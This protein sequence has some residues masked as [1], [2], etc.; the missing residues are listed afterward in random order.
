M[1]TLLEKLVWDKQAEADRLKLELPLRV[2][3]EKLPTEPRYDFGMALRTPGTHII[4]ELPVRQVQS[5]M[6]A[7]NYLTDLALKYQTGGASALSVIC[8]GR[9]PGA[10]YEQLEAVKC[11][12]GLPVLCKEIIV[13]PYQIHYARFMNADAVLLMAGIMTRQGLANCLKVTA[14]LNLTAIVEVHNPHEVSIAV[15]AGATNISCMAAEGTP[16]NHR[17]TAVKLANDLSKDVLKI[18]GAG[19][20]N[21]GDLEQ[22]KAAGFSAFIVGEALAQAADPAA[23]IR[24][25]H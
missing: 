13:D 7:D 23:L 21:S 22:L 19:I 6:S 8:D 10:R 2:I 17:E 12:A 15:E 11:A 1:T 25:L 24:T 4:A 18:G 20:Q 3:A 14:G 9:F 16:Q 5:G